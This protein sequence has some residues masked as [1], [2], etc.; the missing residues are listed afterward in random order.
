MPICSG[1]V[2]KET[3]STL[4]LM[5]EVISRNLQLREVV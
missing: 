4:S 5:L 2:Q 3:G 1:H